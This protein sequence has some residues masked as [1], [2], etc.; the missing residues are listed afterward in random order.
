MMSEDQ[1]F[2]ILLLDTV[3]SRTV[4]EL[5][6]DHPEYNETFRDFT[7]FENTVGG[8]F[9]V[10]RDLYRISCPENGMKMMNHLMII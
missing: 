10:L 4:T 8:L 5:L 3:D 1:N 7:Y 2:V 6:A 9:R